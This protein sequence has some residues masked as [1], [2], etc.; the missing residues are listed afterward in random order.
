MNGA[1]QE[2]SR[3]AEPAAPQEHI[4]RYWNLRSPAYDEQ[5]G[6]GIRHEDERQVW[7]TALAQLLPP[8][9]ADVLDVG[10]GTGFLALLLAEM[11]HRVT[12]V[13][14]SEGMLALARTKA[15]GL[16]RNMPQPVFQ[17]GDAID[18]PLPPGSVDVIINRHLLWTLTDPERAFANWHFLL[19]PGGRLVAIDGLWQ[20]ARRAESPPPQSQPPES[21]RELWARYYTD[22]VQN[23]LP[24]FDVET[25]D[26][27]VAAVRRAG[28]LQVRASGLEEVDRLEQELTPDRPPRRPRYVITAVRG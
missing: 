11:G 6:H 3:V 23:V 24:L 8:A 28:F 15:A 12:G 5:P 27:V 22:A 4:T 20:L 10:T 2:Q 1:E 25:L 13:D 9:P 18:P 7:L 26:P 16:K 21:W 14:L 17:M 19:R